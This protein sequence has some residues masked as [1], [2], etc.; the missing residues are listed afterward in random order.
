MRIGTDGCWT[1]PNGKLHDAR[2]YLLPS[3]LYPPPPVNK[4]MEFNTRKQSSGLSKIILG[5][6]AAASAVIVALLG[7]SQME[8]TT[9]IKEPMPIVRPSDLFYDLMLPEVQKL[10]AKG[11]SDISV[12]LPSDENYRHNLA[13]VDKISSKLRGNKLVNGEGFILAN[14]YDPQSE[15][16]LGELLAEKRKGKDIEV[17]TLP[18]GRIIKAEPGYSTQQRR[19]ALALSLLELSKDE[20]K[21]TIVYVNDLNENKDVI[22]AMKL[23]KW[24]LNIHVLVFNLHVTKKIEYENLTNI[25]Y[26]ELLDS[27]NKLREEEFK[28]MRKVFPPNI[29]KDTQDLAKPA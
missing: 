13:A 6:I 7:S 25:T 12:Y 26:K 10:R 28:R 19:Y 1:T 21:K 15:N 18:G 17:V 2:K 14:R 24:P 3:Y 29:D 5:G 22:E 8:D 16:K 4:R 23:L 20:T 27:G 11:Y 9:P